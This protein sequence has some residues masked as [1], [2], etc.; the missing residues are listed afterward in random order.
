MIEPTG[1][2]SASRS[3]PLSDHALG[4]LR[5]IGKSPV[6][7]FLVNPGVSS[8]LLRDGL[9]EDVLLPSPCKK[10]KGKARSHLRITVSGMDLL[11]A[12]FLSPPAQLEPEQTEQVIEYGPSLITLARLLREGY[13]A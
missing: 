7:R 1:N 2:A 10:D 4:V 3:R 9:V 13:F 12:F 8:R 6:P 5:D 11:Q